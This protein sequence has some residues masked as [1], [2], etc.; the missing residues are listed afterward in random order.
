[1]DRRDR[2]EHD[3]TK[4]SIALSW[5]PVPGTQKYNISVDG[6]IVTS[7]VPPTVHGLSVAAGDTVSVAAVPIPTPPPTPPTPPATSWPSALTTL[8]GSFTPPS[9]PT[10]T[11]TTAAQLAALN[12]VAGDDVLVKAA[13]YPGQFN[14]GWQLPAG[15]I[16]AR[17]KFEQGVL[18]NGG[19]STIACLNITSRG[20]LYEGPA[21]VTWP[22]WDNVLLTNTVD[23]I[24]KDLISHGAGTSGIY[25]GA[26]S[27]KVTSNTW[28]VDCE[29]YNNGPQPPNYT[30]STAWASYDPPQ[31]AWAGAH[32]CY[33]MG[34][35]GSGKG[36]GIIGCNIHDQHNG[37]GIQAY[38]AWAGGVIDGC[39]FTNIDGKVSGPDSALVRGTAGDRAGIG[40]M[41][42]GD[43]LNVTLG[44]GNTF[45]NCV[46]ENIDVDGGA[47]VTQ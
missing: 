45:A 9:A 1:V 6:K 11:I 47:V 27:G 3:V 44:K 34:G 8:Y 36:G 13:T 41:C 28:I 38:G 37:Y 31:Y 40:I 7:S 19:G 32:G 22:T 2:R 4:V 29:L 39:T 16:S 14:M 33:F 46:Y 5:P 17:I 15:K 43:G 10:K 26:D 23:T 18:F 42:Y 30:P 35:D 12:L 24:V 25:I 21:E 20:V